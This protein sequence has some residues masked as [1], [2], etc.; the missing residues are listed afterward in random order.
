MK[1]AAIARGNDEASVD[2]FYL[3]GPKAMEDFNRTNGLNLPMN[4][5]AGL[6]T[7]QHAA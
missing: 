3:K 1:A 5:A 4:E 7:K 2:S 6:E